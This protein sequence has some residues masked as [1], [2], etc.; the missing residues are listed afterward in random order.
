MAKPIAIDLFSGSGGLTLGLK[1]AGFRVAGAIEVNPLAVETYREN[2]K[3]IPIWTKDIRRISASHMMK[4]LKLRPKQLDLLAG[5]PPCEGFSAL[6]TL[7]GSRSIRDHR[8]DLIFEFLRFVRTFQPRAIM[9]E[10]VPNLSKDKRF[11]RFCRALRTLGY[12]LDHRVLNAADYGVPQRR[13]RLLLLASRQG[14]VTFA[15]VSVKRAT[16]RGAIGRLPRPSNSK[17]KLHNIRESRTPRVRELIRRIPKDGGSRL[18][19]GAKYQLQCHRRCDGFKD[20]YGRLAWDDVS[21]TITGGCFN[22]S[23]GRFLH[24]S[25]NRT[26]TL[27]EAALLQTFP[28]DYFFSLRQGKSQAASLIGDALP[29]EFVRQHAKAVREFLLA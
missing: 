23:K 15:S 29:P 2:H 4:R 8:N 20:I 1:R 24:P 16:V 11:F 14:Q 7:N 13:R 5:C 27:R 10:N 28:V 21:S 12:Q 26:I 3:R 6:R 18:D 17:D 19:A 9:L 22:P 25:Q